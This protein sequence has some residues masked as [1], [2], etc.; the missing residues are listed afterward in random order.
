MCS[1]RFTLTTRSRHVMERQL[2]TAQRLGHLRQVKYLLALLAVGEGQ[3]FAEVAMGLRVPEKTVATWVQRVCCDG[4]KGA[5]RKKPTGRPPKLTPTQKATLV[6]LIDEGPSTAGF[7]SACWRSPMIQP[8]IYDR[9][10]VFSNVFYIAQLLKHLGFSYQKA[11]FVSDHLDESKRRTWRI[12]TWPQILRRAKERQALLLFGDEAS[13][14]QWG[15]LTYTWARR[16]QQP[17]VKTSGKRKGYKVFG[18]IDYFTGCFLYQGQEGRL[19]STAY[20]VFLKRVLEQT[21]QH[22]ILIQD[23]AKYHTS[24]ET[25]AFFAQQT[26]RLEVF[27]LPSYSPDDNP[28]EK[29]W[30]KVKK[31]GPPLQ[32]FPTFEALTAKV[33]HAL[34]KFANTPEEMLSLCSLPTELAKA[35]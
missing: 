8:L 7:S 26:A 29:L 23:G 24:A 6:T 27:Q 17:H 31:E 18:L 15:T 30:K 25:K 9:F 10:G 32:Y 16:G 22:I 19:N 2:E 12:T 35:A 20:M 34:L 5:P 21:T 4:L 33:E 13:F 14:P 3:S 1:V 11:A 28:I